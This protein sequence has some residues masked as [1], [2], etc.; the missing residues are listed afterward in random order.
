M[1]HG[2]DRAPLGVQ[3][4]LRRLESLVLEHMEQLPHQTPRIG[5]RLCEE[6]EPLEDDR[7]PEN[8]AEENG[9]H[10]DP[11]RDVELDQPAFIRDP[12][13]DAGLGPRGRGR[14]ERGHGNERDPEPV[15][16]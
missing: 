11:A 7:E 2:R 3:H 10:E 8:G 12:A 5:A 14:K 4:P 16:E 6:V 13:L 1:Q 15:G 9:V